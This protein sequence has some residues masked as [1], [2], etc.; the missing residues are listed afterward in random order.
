M[1]RNLQLAS[2]TGI[3]TTDNQIRCMAHVINLSVQVVLSHLK[4]TPTDKEDRTDN[5][6]SVNR[7]PE[8]FG[9]ARQ[10][11]SKIRASNLLWERFEAQNAVAQIPVLKLA[12]DIP[13]RKI[14][15]NN[16]IPSSCLEAAGSPSGN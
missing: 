4:V 16:Q 11:I 10:I 13:V 7:I 5:S 8:V 15:S 9:R 1:L 12:L 2:L 14:L 6:E 3:N